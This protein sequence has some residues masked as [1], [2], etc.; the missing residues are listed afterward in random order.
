MLRCLLTVFITGTCVAGVAHAAGVCPD[1]YTEYAGPEIDGMRA[2]ANGECSPLCAAGVTQINM[3]GGASAWLFE[4]KTTSPSLNV[5]FPDGAVCYIDLGTGGGQG[6]NVSDGKNTYHTYMTPPCARTLTLSYSCG[7][8][9]GGDAPESRAILYG[10]LFVPG[11]DIGTCYKTG[12]MFAGWTLDG[13]DVGTE[14]WRTYTYDS[15]KT[16]VA[17]WIT[18][19]YAVGY[20][21]SECADVPTEPKLKHVGQYGQTFQ[22]VNPGDSDGP[23]C[24]FTSKFTGYKIMYTD[25]TDTGD[26]VA[27]SGTFTYKYDDNIRLVA[28]WE[29]EEWPDRTYTL[30]YSCGD[31]AGTPPESIQ[32]SYGELFTPPVDMGGCTRAGYL[33]T[34]WA[35]SHV[36]ESVGVSEDIELASYQLNL[37]TWTSDKTLVAQWTPADYTAAYVCDNGTV[38]K[39]YVSKLVYGASVTPDVSVCVAPDGKKFAGYQILYSDGTDAG[40]TVAPGA[41]F[42]FNYDDNLRFVAL[43]EQEV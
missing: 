39:K 5:M 37:Y 13:A 3:S 9:D 16:L 8:A 36:D 43:W 14:N 33:F 38:S 2:N 27:P 21:C 22:V 20:A 6:L 31:G 25:G 41:S 29:N 28:Q 30:V 18:S 32:I 17:K 19:D 34:G 11:Y 15:D 12:H 26:T 40:A 7:D 24:P 42:I 4:N 1:N 23:I 10:A 35:M